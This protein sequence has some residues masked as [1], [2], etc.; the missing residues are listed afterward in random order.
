MG[1]H[2]SKSELDQMSSWRAAGKTPIDIHTK[3]CAQRRRRN[4][5][6][7]CLTAIR[8]ALHGITHKRSRVETRG[9]PKVLSSRNLKTVDAT[10]KRLIAKADNTREI[11]WSDLLRA[12]R[13]P[14]VDPTMLAKNMRAAGY[15]VKWRPPRLKVCRGKI[16]EQQRKRICDKLRKLP[17]SYWIRQ[18]DLIMDNKKYQTPTSLKGKKYLKSLRVRGHLRTKAEGLKPGFTKPHPCKHRRNVGGTS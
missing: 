14:K 16:D 10:R 5:G 8:R 2:V 6:E 9:R 18:I 7:P 17:V 11:H 1:R 13:V 12:S 15:D 4:E 3:L